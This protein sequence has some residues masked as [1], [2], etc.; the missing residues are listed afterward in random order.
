VVTRRSRKAK[1][2]ARREPHA[3][4]GHAH[5]ALQQTAGRRLL[6]ALALTVGFAGFEALAGL[7]SGSLT[8]L[9]DAGH[10]VTDAVALALATLAAWIAT[11]PPSPRHSYG[12]GRAEVVA[13]LVNALFMLAIVIGIVVEAIERLRTPQ[14]VLGG[15]V[16]LVASAGLAV[17]VAVVVALR[18][19]AQT[20]NVRAAVLHVMGDVLGSIAALIAGGVIYFTGWTAIDPILS[21]VICL[22]I[23]LSSLKLIRD[24]LH[25]IME[26][27]P[28]HL[29]LQEVGRAMASADP[30]VK[31]VHDLHIW[32]LSSGMIALSA[33]VMIDDMRHWQEVLPRL[34][35]LLHERFAI[36]HV[37]VQ[38]ETA[39]YV[40]RPLVR[41][42]RR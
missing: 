42:K 36:E 26:G 40:L 19:E 17:N 18:G 4:A 6:I 11:H 13:A 16:M 20:L 32:T 41:R 33:H 5:G 25:V 21:L 10:M 15:V 38:P 12:L 34:T 2:P 7:W 31:S 22:L 24:A 39:T 9:G 30:R 3:H 14:P 35:R 29:D 8:L 28:A 23:L 1:E 37:T 27:V